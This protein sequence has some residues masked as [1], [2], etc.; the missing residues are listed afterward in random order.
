[1]GLQR[2][3]AAGSARGLAA[4]CWQFAHACRL[5][6]PKF[7]LAA[8]RHFLLAFARLNIDHILVQARSSSVASSSSAAPAPQSAVIPPDWSQWVQNQVQRQM[9]KIQRLFQPNYW[10]NRR[11]RRQHPRRGDDDRWGDRRRSPAP[12]RESFVGDGGRPR[13][14]WRQEHDPTAGQW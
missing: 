7:L 6:R 9:A 5:S 10:D 2:D 3:H 12:R 8:C 14:P 4:Q 11:G 1:V 13:D